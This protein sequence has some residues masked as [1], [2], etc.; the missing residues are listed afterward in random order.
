MATQ[1][2]R[3]RGTTAENDNFTGAMAEFTFDTETHHIRVHDGVK[4]GGYVIPVI[5]DPLNPGSYTKVTIDDQGLV[6]GAEPLSADDLPNEIPMDKVFGLPLA[7][8]NKQDKIYAGENIVINETT[9]SAIDT[10]YTAGE[11]IDITDNVI[12]ATGGSGGTSNYNNLTN[13][14][15][16]NSVEL[17]GNKTLSDLGIQPAGDYATT[18][19]LAEK[20]DTISDLGAIRTNASAGAGAATTISGYGDVVTHNANEFQ[21]AGDYATKAELGQK[22][23]TIS[24]LNTIRSDASTGAGLSPQ[25]STNTSDITTLKGKVQEIESARVPNAIIV[26][27]P[28]IQQGQISG[29][30]NEDYMQFPFLVDLTNKRFTINFCFTTGDDVTTQQ[31]I[32]DSY[33]GLALAIRNGKGLMAISHNGTSWMG[34]IVGTMTIDPNTTYYAQLSWNRINY[35]TKLS[36]DGTIFTPDMNFG[37]IQSPYPRTMFIGGSP[38]LFGPGTAHPFKGSINF[39]KCS[40]YEEDVEKWQGMDDVGLATRATT[41]LDNLDAAGQARFDAKA[42]ASDFNTH[43]ADTVAHVTQSEKDAW[44]GKFDASKIV[45]TTSTPT[46][47]VDGTIYFVGE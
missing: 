21:V 46:E 8:E 25:V 24:D 15:S 45:F 38:D 2:K 36:T 19:E 28:I 23:D 17:S 30:S 40:F 13:K 3:R 34:E 22:Q 14:P 16:I 47:F 44:D 33:F 35:Q 42:N 43:T 9:I 37:S 7:L 27:S 18:G 32:L 6:I 12:S 41:S 39:Y 31:N 26:G 1:V 29:F 5:T 20:Q 4:Q 10:K 11:G